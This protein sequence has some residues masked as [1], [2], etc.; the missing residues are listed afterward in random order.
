MDL[1]RPLP[2]RYYYVKPKKKESGSGQA[3]LVLAGVTLAI[4]G[5]AIYVLGRPEDE[6][7]GLHV[8]AN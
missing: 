1:I 2:R 5:G 8:R 4:T 7:I 3:I 6:I